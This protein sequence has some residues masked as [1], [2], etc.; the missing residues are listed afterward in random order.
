MIATLKFKLPEDE[1]DLLLAQSGALYKGVLDD[2][3][4]WLRN[5][6]KYQEISKAEREIYTLTRQYLNNLLNDIR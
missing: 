1:E 6:I 5:K 3:D 4:N 2:M